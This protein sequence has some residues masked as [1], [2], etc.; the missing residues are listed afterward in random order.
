[1]PPIY[2][3]HRCNEWRPSQPNERSSNGHCVN[4]RWTVDY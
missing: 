2:T 1:L 3:T 4:S